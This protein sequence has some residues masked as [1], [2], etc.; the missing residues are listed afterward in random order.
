MGSKISFWDE[1]REKERVTLV[2]KNG[3]KI[4]GSGEKI[5]KFLQENPH[6]KWEEIIYEPEATT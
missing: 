5:A 1:L 3:K 6:E 4:T 2:L